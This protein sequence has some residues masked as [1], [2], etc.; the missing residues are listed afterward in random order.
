VLKLPYTHSCFVCGDSNPGGLKLRFEV[1]EGQVRTNF[2][3]GREHV[4][5]RDTVHGGLIATLLDECMVW[6]CAVA[7]RRFAYCGELNVRFLNPLRPGE[8][9]RVTADLV[10]NR[11]DKIFDARAEMLGP[12]GVRI[13]TATG[14]YLPV[15]DADIPALLEDFA[16]DTEGLL[17]PA[18]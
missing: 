6:A 18:S 15:R 4:G 10:A 3:P 11:R 1:H 7:T 9:A 2:Q 14:K 17:P 13:A 5:F 16:G 12:T 8:L